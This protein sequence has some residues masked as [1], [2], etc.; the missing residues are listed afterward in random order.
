MRINVLKKWESNTTDEISIPEE[1]NIRR[2]KARVF[3]E[4]RRAERVRTKY[5]DVRNGSDGSGGSGHNRQKYA[6]VRNGS[7]NR[8]AAKRPSGD[9]SIKNGSADGKRIRIPCEQDYDLKSG[10]DE[11]DMADDAGLKGY[12][13][14]TGKRARNRIII[15]AI[16]VCVVLTG[17]RLIYGPAILTA[18]ITAYENEKIEIIGLTDQ[19]FYVTPGQLSKLKMTRVIATG[20]SEKAGTVTGI[21]PTLDTFLEEYGDGAV[22]SDFKEVKFYAQDKYSTS[23]VKTLQEDT[24][25]LSV[26]NGSTALEEYQQPLRIV[27]PEEDSSSW[28]RMVTAIEFTWN[29]E[30]KGAEDSEE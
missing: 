24:I 12:Y 19:D 8:D 30:D 1:K 25:V 23:L 17:V 9:R 13:R 7:E 16:A 29:N 14:R 27:I 5:R 2:E 21:G 18:N 3:R 4:K 22:R 6:D 15:A 28:I 10:R 26:A 11:R 20:K